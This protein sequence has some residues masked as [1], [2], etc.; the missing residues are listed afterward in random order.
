MKLN[1]ASVYEAFW[2]ILIEN[3]AVTNQVVEVT[4]PKNWLA[5]LF[6]CDKCFTFRRKSII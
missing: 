2:L 3:W 5:Q 4:H 6:L 1:F